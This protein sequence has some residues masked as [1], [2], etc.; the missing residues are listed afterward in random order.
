VLHGVQLAGNTA[1]SGGGGGLYSLG[2]TDVTASRVAGNSALQGG[3]LY[4]WGGGNIVN[5]LLADNQASAAG[6][7]L[8][9]NFHGDVSILFSTIAA[10]T[11]NPRQAIVLYSSSSLHVTDTILSNYAV[12]ISATTGST[13]FEN[14]NL[15][16]GNTVNSQGSMTH[17][18]GS[19]IGQNPLFVNP[20][21][22]DYHLTGSSPAIDH[23]TNAGIYVDY[24]GDVRPLGFGYDIGFDER[25][26]VALNNKVYLPLALKNY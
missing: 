14:Y 3:G 22:G 23:G 15:F 20:G 11:L 19:L 8:Y 24:D 6:A 17:G 16:Y 13:A 18:G 4:F 1:T 26:A 7:D 25:L 10:A 12:G 21:A 9:V 5:S 2:Q